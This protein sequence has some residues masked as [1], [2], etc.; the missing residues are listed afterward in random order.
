MFSRRL[1]A[2]QLTVAPLGLGMVRA[3]GRV[4]VARPG[5]CLVFRRRTRIAFFSRQKILNGV[6]LLIRDCMASQHNHG[7]DG[8]QTRPPLRR[9]SSHRRRCQNISVCRHKT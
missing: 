8:N 5:C 1:H 2:W 7:L 4:F 9:S 3:C 6:P